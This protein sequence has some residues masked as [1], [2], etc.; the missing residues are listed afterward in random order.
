MKDCFW[1]IIDTQK[2]EPRFCYAKK[3]KALGAMAIYDQKPVIPDEWKHLKKVVRVT[4]T[5]D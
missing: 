4:I 1:A 2:D 3:N 5:T